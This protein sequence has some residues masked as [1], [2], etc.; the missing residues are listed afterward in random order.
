MINTTYMYKLKERQSGSLS[1]ENKNQAFTDNLQEKQ[2]PFLALH[3][4]EKDRDSK[5]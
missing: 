2:Q 4:C 3:E 1:K 5:K